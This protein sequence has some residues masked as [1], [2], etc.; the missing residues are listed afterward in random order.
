MYINV[1][2]R[3][4]VLCKSEA[5]WQTVITDVHCLQ[6]QSLW[7]GRRTSGHWFLA[8]WLC[9]S[10]AQT[11]ILYSKFSVSLYVT[12]WIDLN[13]SIL[14]SRSSEWR[15]LINSLSEDLRYKVLL[16]G[17]YQ[18]LKRW[19]AISMCLCHWCFASWV[20]EMKHK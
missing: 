16:F 13:S 18:T 10:V 7:M 20:R 1:T 17:E 14:Q 4:C 3:L 5:L 12:I 8:L 9:P 6:L 11:F 15:G 2:L 19:R